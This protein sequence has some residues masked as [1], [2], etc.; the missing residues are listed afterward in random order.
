MKYRRANRDDIDLFVKNR[1]EFVTSIKEINN[2]EDFKNRTKQYIKEHIEDDDLIIFI[3]IDKNR[4]VSS[5]M[6]S[7]FHTVPKPSSPKGIN[8]ELLNV[9]TIKEYRRKGYAEKLISMLIQEVKNLGVEK[10]VL[11]Y[12]DM[13]LPLYEKFGFTTSHNQMQLKL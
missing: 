7:I 1:I 11:D 13:G 6:A 8:A 3:A 2:I 10:I 9:Y 4:I 12:T 5:C